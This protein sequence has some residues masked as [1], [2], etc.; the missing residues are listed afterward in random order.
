MA[1]NQPF[2][3]PA[4]TGLIQFIHPKLLK[5]CDRSEFANSLGKY[6]TGIVWSKS[7][8]GN[9]TR[10]NILAAAQA[11]LASIGITYIKDEALNL[12]IADGDT[13]EYAA[14]GL[15][16]TWSKNL[17]TTLAK[18]KAES[19]PPRVLQLPAEDEQN[20]DLVLDPTRSI[21]KHGDWGFCRIKVGV[22]FIAVVNQDLL[23]LYKAQGKYLHEGN[24]DCVVSIG[25][26]EV[27][28]SHAGD[29]SKFLG[30]DRGIAATKSM[31]A[32]YKAPAKGAA[33]SEDPM[34]APQ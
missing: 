10:A 17:A 33:G 28:R 5:P 18:G 24:K 20:Q 16:G 9:L 26:T 21:V 12:N 14:K 23:K 25:L 4:A 34:F 27:V 1:T 22:S 13:E 7:D 2:W 29:G 8:T 6:S 15:A 32:G 30:G 19:N 11:F 3:V 31:F